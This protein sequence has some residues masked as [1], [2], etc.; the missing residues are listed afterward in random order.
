MKRRPGAVYFTQVSC[1]LYVLLSPITSSLRDGPVST[2]GGA[3]TS[4]AADRYQCNGSDEAT[5]LN[6]TVENIYL[7]KLNGL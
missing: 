6:N 3:S 7:A 1:T 5:Q 4:G 2:V